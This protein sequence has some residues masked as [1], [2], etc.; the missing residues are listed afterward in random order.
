MLLNYNCRKQTE[1][2]GQ[3]RNFSGPVDCGDYKTFKNNVSIRTFPQALL[4]RHFYYLDCMFWYIF[5][6][7]SMVQL[8]IG[9]VVYMSYLSETFLQDCLHEQEQTDLYIC[10]T[11]QRAK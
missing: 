10:T 5:E 3:G 8:H 9:A 7:N 4:L 11:Q 2:W 1:F 6:Y